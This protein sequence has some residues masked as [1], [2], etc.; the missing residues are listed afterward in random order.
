[1]YPFSEVNKVQEEIRKY[2]P[3]QCYLLYDSNTINHCDNIIRNQFPDLNDSERIIIPA[4]DQYKT[5]ER[6]ITI[7]NTLAKIGANRNSLLINVGGG[8][9]TDI[10]GF[11]A[12][13]YK[14]GIAFINIPT[15]LLGMVDACVG[16]K[17]G[18][19]FNNFKNQLGVFANAQCIYINT[20]FLESL[21]LNE[22][23]SGLGEMIK[24]LLLFKEDALEFILK[25][26]DIKNWTSESCI[27]KNIQLKKAIVEIDYLDNNE[28]Q[29][30]NFGHTIGHAIESLS[31]EKKT[32]LLHGEAVLLG[33]IEELKLSEKLYNTPEEIRAVLEAVKQKFFPFLDFRYKFEKLIPFL[34]QDKKN[35]NGIRFSLLENVAKPKLKVVISLEELKNE[36][37]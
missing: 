20:Q 16:G 35:E 29:C 15:S 27:L 28:R 11:A 1:V 21:P 23:Y 26:T 14:R 17:T 22:L 6:C 34:Q 30:L 2:D 3:M 7:W 4:G 9:I 13:N 10:G 33:M 19:N 36:L 37:S 8:M 32:P 5:L 18:I 25:N 31:H 24:H 12:S